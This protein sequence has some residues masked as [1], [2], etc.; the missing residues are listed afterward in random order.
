MAGSLRFCELN[1]L[2]T[3]VTDGIMLALH[4]VSKGNLE[5]AALGKR[6]VKHA[7]MQRFRGLH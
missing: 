2:I 7:T 3:S 1:V 5:L 4:S 6:G